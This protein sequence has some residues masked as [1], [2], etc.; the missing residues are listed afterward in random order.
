M[1]LMRVFNIR[2]GH[3][4]AHD[5]I[6]PRLIEAP[7]E[8]VAAGITIGPVYD[9]MVDTYYESMKWDKAGKPLPETLKRLGLD[10]V[11]SDLEKQ[12]SS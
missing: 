12:G 11:A 10:Y 5:T 7:T 4:R 6:S 1:N 9:E 8:G 3:S 2:H